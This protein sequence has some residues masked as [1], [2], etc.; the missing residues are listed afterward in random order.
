MVSKEKT[1]APTTQKIGSRQFRICPFSE[2][3]E[4][5]GKLAGQ[6]GAVTYFVGF[7]DDLEAFFPMAE[8]IHF[9]RQGKK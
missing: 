9:R 6:L 2:L 4:M 7:L 1:L 8:V 5:R 3:N